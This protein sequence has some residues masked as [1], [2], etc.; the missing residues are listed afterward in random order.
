MHPARSLVAL[1][2][3][4]C[5]LAV[6]APAQVDPAAAEPAPRAGDAARGDALTVYL[7][8]MGQGDQVWEKFG[9]NALW[10][11][12]PV[13]GTDRV[14][15]YGVFDFDSPGYWSRFVRGTWIYQL[16]VE[17]IR[18][19]VYAYRYFDRML[20]AQELAL[21]GA[22]KAQLQAFLEWNARPENREYRYDYFRDNCSTRLRD[23]LDRVLG[24]RLRAATEALPTGT[25]YRWHSRRLLADDVVTYAGLEAGLG[26][27]ADREITRWEELF[28]PGELH[29][30]V[31]DL[32]VERNGREIPL[33]VEERVLYRAERAPER[34]APPFRL[35]WYLV[36]GV[37]F[38]G[39]LAWLGRP[40]AG[41]ASRFGFAALSSLWSLVVGVGGLILI[42]LWAFT[43]HRIAYRNENILH[44]DPLVLGLAV[45]LPAL[46]YG[47][48]WAQR[49]ARMVAVAAAAISL[50]GFALQPLPGVDQVNG[51]IIALLLPVHLALAATAVRATER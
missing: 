7:L 46:A 21:T 29:D 2:V 14:Y 16:A 48:R 31:G 17:D 41:A 40:D 42:G 19:T 18:N 44:F 13:A 27:A 5:G 20:V 32:T 8:T 23:V 49:P 12:D 43:D 15:N 26:P 45:L 6:R 35:P 47:A 38:A 50:L 4:V 24:G 3:A 34:E 28:L 11:H 30:A 25:T 10:I 22:E 33:V 1:V 39:V 36:A 37:A 51:E 9:H